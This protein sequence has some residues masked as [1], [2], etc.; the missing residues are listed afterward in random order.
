MAVVVD[1][2][3]DD[4][5]VAVFAVV[6]SKQPLYTVIMT[7]YTIYLRRKKY[8]YS[9]IHSWLSKHLLLGSS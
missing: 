8:T 5:D 7:K 9:S 2:V 3:D 1:V 6:L 4:D